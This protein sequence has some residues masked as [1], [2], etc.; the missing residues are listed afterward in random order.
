MT[1]LGAV[2]TGVAVATVEI[3][4][5]TPMAG[6]AGR[7]GMSTGTHDPTTVRALVWGRIGLVSVDVCALHEDTCRRI[8]TES[9][10]DA[11]VVSAVHTHSGPSVGCGRV[12][13]HDE[14]VHESIVQAAVEAL[15]S[16]YA[17]QAPCTVWSTRVYGL[18]VARDR[19]HLDQTIDP[20]LS[21][22]CF[23]GPSGN[24]VAV[25]ASYPCHPVV[26]D[27]T[28]TLISADYVH[29]L[30]TTVEA[31]LGSPC[32]FLTGAA[33]DINTG[34]TASA[35]FSPQNCLDGDCDKEVGAKL[36]QSERTFQHAAKLGERLGRALVDAKWQAS[37]A[38][39]SVRFLSAPIQLEYAD[40][41]ADTVAAERQL[42]VSQMSTADAGL[43]RVLQAWVDWAEA[44]SPQNAYRP[45]NGRVSRIDL[46]GAASV[47]CLPGEPFL[48]AAEELTRDDPFIT[49]A[50]YCDGVP[51]YLPAWADYPEGGY[52]VTDA[53]R[54]YNMPAPFARGS[55]EL[56]VGRARVLMSR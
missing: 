48:A 16:A 47:L 19:R 56:V 30:R 55:L 27:A 3:P 45:W 5:G 42:W 53:C 11:V 41:T 8:E 25:L 24:R 14:E 12:G 4:S 10:L 15:G 31:G 7:L 54:Y 51:G 34:H 29:P 33:G 22:L 39:Q 21:G 49:V 28:N 44:W 35:S 38:A 2:P 52:E 1:A 43:R 40:L 20:P 26:L 36:L 46:G 23:V 18:G 6:F 32:V 37:S 13:G 9:G 17:S 50:G